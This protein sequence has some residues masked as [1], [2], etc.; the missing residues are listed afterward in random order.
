M[1]DDAR[2][3]IRGLTVPT[4]AEAVRGIVLILS[5]YLVITGAE[6]VVTPPANSR[7]LARAIPG[8]TFALVPDAGHSFLFQLPRATGERLTSFLR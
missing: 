5:A 4:G 3:R 1:P 6:D 8:A 7:I 2:L